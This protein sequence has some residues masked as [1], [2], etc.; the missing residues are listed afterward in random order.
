MTASLKSKKLHFYLLFN[1][2]NGNSP[3]LRFL[4]IKKIVERW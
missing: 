4:N 1:G 3:K 2:N